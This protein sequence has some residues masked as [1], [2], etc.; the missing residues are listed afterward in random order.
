MASLACRWNDKDL[1]VCA[2]SYANDRNKIVQGRA[3]ATFSNHAGCPLY[4]FSSCYVDEVL[5]NDKKSAQRLIHSRFN[6]VSN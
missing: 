5:F 6:T 4:V 3:N 2:R 1:R